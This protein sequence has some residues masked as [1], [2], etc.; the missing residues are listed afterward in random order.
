[1]NGASGNNAV[2]ADYDND[3]LVDAFFAG[4]PSLLFHNTGNGSF[5]KQT[6]SAVV[7][8]RGGQG[9]SW[10]DYDNDGF[11]DLVARTIYVLSL[12]WVMP[13]MSM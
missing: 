8:D 2:W 13:P 4:S 11:L 3:G 10:G 6:N 12:D 7:I 9:C 5:T 1:M